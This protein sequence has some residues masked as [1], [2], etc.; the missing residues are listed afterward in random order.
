VE[1]RV[2]LPREQRPGF[3]IGG[4]ALGN[5]GM[6]VS[7]LGLHVRRTC[8][9]TPPGRLSV[10]SRNHVGSGLYVCGFKLRPPSC[11]GLSY[12]LCRELFYSREKLCQT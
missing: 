11:S 9:T 12:R 6:A 2:L 8:A 3:G 10:D 5:S 7:V 1:G 4:Y